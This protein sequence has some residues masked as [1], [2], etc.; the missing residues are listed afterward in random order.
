MNEPQKIWVGEAQNTIPL[1]FERM[2]QNL[3]DLPLVPQ[4]LPC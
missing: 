4:V 3:E 2:E 1:K